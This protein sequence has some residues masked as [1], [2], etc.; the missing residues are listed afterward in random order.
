[1][2]YLSSELRVLT[3]S[4]AADSPNIWTY[5]DTVVQATVAAANYISDAAKSN[6]GGPG[7]GMS[8]GDIVYYR[9]FASLSPKTSLTSIT[10]HSVTNVTATG[11]T[12][13]AGTA[14]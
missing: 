14:I 13:S 1:M 3:N 10:A 12:L 2:P 11:A 8:I 6:T 5:D 9:R 7:R 4:F